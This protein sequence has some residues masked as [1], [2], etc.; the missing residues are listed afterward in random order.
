M[1]TESIGALK[2]RDISLHLR[3]YAA[4]LEKTKKESIEA[5]EREMQQISIC[6]KYALENGL[7]VLGDLPCPE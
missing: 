6:M 5:F 2:I 1:K 4:T 3:S 7:A